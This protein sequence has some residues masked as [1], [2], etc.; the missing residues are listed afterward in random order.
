MACSVRFNLLKSVQ[1]ID[2]TNSL[3]RKK[4]DLLFKPRD[5]FLTKGNIVMDHSF[6]T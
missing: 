2:E 3:K 6:N 1:N 4:N 5:W